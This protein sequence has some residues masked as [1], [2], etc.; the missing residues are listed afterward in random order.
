[1]I[2]KE[3]A[4][5]IVA[6]AEC[7]NFSDKTHLYKQLDG[8]N[9]LNNTTVERLVDFARKKKVFAFVAHR[10]DAITFFTW[11]IALLLRTKLRE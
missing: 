2:T 9:A 5:M 4:F 8:L 11:S 6:W 10:M 3:Y 1:M 7:L